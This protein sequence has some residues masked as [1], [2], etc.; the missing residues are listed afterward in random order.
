VIAPN[1]TP[2][3]T[4]DWSPDGSKILFTRGDTILVA[5]ADGSAPSVLAMV[6]EAHSCAWSPAGDLIACGSQNPQSEQPG[7][8]FGNLAPSKITIIRARD[9]STT[10][11]TDL[12]STNHSPVWAPDGR[13]LYFLSNRDGPRDIY[14]ID[15][16]GSG[17]GR[18]APQRLTTGLGAIAISLSGDGGRL[19]YAVYTTNANLWSLPISS[20]GVV[21]VDR[22]T[23]VTTGNQVIEAM[24]VS[25]DGRWIVYDSNLGG[26]SHIWRMPIEGGTPQQLTNG[27]A[28]E[29][30]GDL[31]PDGQLLAYHSWRTGT[32]DIEV[33]SL[34]GG[35][36]ERV[37]DTPGQ[38]SYPV[39]SRDGNA[40]LYFTQAAPRQVHLVTRSA[41]GTWSTPRVVA[42]MP[43]QSRVSWSPD[44]TSVVITETGAARI[45]IAS[46]DGSGSRELFVPEPGRPRPAQ[47]NWGADGLIYFKAFDASG[48]ASFWSISPLGGAPRLLARLD[49]LS[50]PSSRTDFAIHEDRLYFAI[51][52]RQSD[53][54]TVEVTRK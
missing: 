46:I 15:I 5:N 47:S 32:R 12:R 27:P 21:G 44:N 45:T 6:P 39:W 10:A 13:R 35:E 53:V 14:A 48:R 11:V 29:F 23:A 28:D 25:S 36:P 24:E 4:A 43:G 34:A 8:I 22:A 19:A 52:D 31:S 51:E 17:A 33:V 1:A 7:P 20:T 2:V 50:K 18:G 40:I 3:S 16:S 42:T 54:Y 37:S 26:R 30:A 9:G 38:E 41:D 49:D